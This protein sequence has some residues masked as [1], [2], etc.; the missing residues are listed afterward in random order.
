MQLSPIVLTRGIAASLGGALPIV[1]LTEGAN[2]IG[3]IG[4][5]INA[6]S[7]APP[8]L[9][10]FF[11]H[12][13]VLPGGTL[14]NNQAATMPF[15][16]QSVAANAIIT[17]PLNISLKMVCPARNLAGVFTKLATLM[18]LKLTLA[19]HNN[20]GGTY[21]IMTPAGIFNDCIMTPAMRDITGGSGDQKQQEW[22]LD[23]LQP[24]VTLD[25]AQNALNGLMQKLT[26]GTAL[27]GTPS[28]LTGAGLPVGNPLSLLSS[29]L[30]PQSSLGAGSALQA[31]TQ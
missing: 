26:N 10:D 21:T 29:S 11:A 4:N 8:N 22:Q 30:V 6:F 1:A 14:I 3:Q 2:F 23:F 24:L 13:D 15:A 12:F 27:S 20:L 19:Q 17:Q 18:A 9:E 31:A 28:W 16:N 7:G 25:A 5:L